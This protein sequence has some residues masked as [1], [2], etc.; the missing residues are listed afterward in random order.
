MNDPIR[1]APP[2]IRDFLVYLE[3]IMGRSPATVNEYFLDL[4]TFFRYI[5]QKKQLSPPDVPFDEISLDGVDLE[6]VK[7][8]TRS[9]VLDY[10]VF[11][12]RE[13]PQHH[14][15]PETTYGNSARTRARKVSALRGFYRYYCD[16]MQLIEE[17]PTRSLDTPKARR[18]LPTVPGTGLR[19]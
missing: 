3:T 8:I 6:L 10:L 12:G 5:L 7:Q 13:R 14:K 4:R 17:N 16:K 15:S 9:D 18:E 1:T 19:R 2:V 11:A